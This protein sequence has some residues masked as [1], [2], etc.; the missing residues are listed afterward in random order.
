VFSLKLSVKDTVTNVLSSICLAT[1]VG[2]MFEIPLHI[3]STESKVSCSV[4]PSDSFE[5][6]TKLQQPLS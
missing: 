5:W 4:M 6:Q 3:Y 2:V 1:N